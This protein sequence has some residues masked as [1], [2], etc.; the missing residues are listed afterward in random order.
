MTIASTT[1]KITYSGDGGTTEF[2]VPFRFLDQEDIVVTLTDAD[3]TATVQTLT[4]EY[5]VSGAGE[6]SGGTVTMVSA[7]GATDS[8]TIKNDPPQTQETDYQENDAFPAESHETALDKLTLICQSLGEQIARSVLLPVSSEI[9]GLTLPEPAA[10]KTLGWNDT[11]DSLENLTPNADAYITL[12]LSVAQG[13]TGA[14]TVGT[15]LTAF[16]FSDFIKTLLDNATASD[17]CGTLGAGA[18]GLD[19]FGAED[20]DAVRTLLELGTAAGVDTGSTIGDVIVLEDVGGMPGLPAVD[21]SQLTGISGDSSSSTLP[22]NYIAGFVPSNDSGDYDHDLTFTAGEC[23]D[24]SGM[25][26]I[27][28]ASDWTFKCDTAWASGDGQGKLQ[29]NQSW[30]AAAG[31]LHIYS[32]AMASGASPDFLVCVSNGAPGMPSGYVYKRRLLSTKIDTGIIQRFDASSLAGGGLDIVWKTPELDVDVSNQGTTSA[33]R[34][35]N[36]GRP[37]YDTGD[38]AAS[39]GFVAR[40]IVLIAHATATSGKIYL[41]NDSA[42]DAGVPSESAAPL[43]HVSCQVNSIGTVGMFNIRTSRS[44]TL[45]SK[46][47]AAD[48]TLKLSTHAFVD[49]RVH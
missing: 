29:S 24:A 46:G 17:A 35:L 15:A 7:P 41:Y 20:A 38:Y 19:V 13:G 27:T 2:A 6:A 3:G 23:R 12:P 30:P 37:P 10:G 36:V 4:T 45:Y 22:K 43:C 32:I 28:L 1:N 18:M 25:V 11:E 39:E 5:T 49:E 48:T 9:S 42:S 14:T 21:G 47:A 33:V 26:D 44:G 8:L 40:G 16:G 34:T 31:D